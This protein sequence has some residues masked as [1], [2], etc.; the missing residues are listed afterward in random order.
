MMKRLSL[1]V[2]LAFAV[3]YGKTGPF[4]KQGPE[5]T[6]CTSHDVCSAVEGAPFCHKIKN[7]PSQGVCDDCASCKS[8][9]DGIGNDCGPC[10]D[11]VYG[12]PKP[13]KPNGSKKGAGAGGKKKKEEPAE[14]EE[15]EEVP[16]Q[17]PPKEEKDEEEPADTKEEKTSG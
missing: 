13:K 16:V 7:D 8:C 1:I 3:V 11:C 12:T 6:M 17:K 4:W 15:E 5:A 10:P 9:K 2:L 14:E